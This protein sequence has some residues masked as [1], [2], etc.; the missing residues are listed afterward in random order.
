MPMSKRF[1]GAFLM[2]ALAGCGHA[3]AQPRYQLQMSMVEYAQLLKTPLFVQVT[4]ILKQANALRAENGLP[5]LKYD[6]SLGRAAAY[7]TQD[8][9][10]RNYSAHTTAEGETVED[11]FRKYNVT[12]SWS[13]EN[14]A[15]FQFPGDVAGTK[16]VE[17]AMNFWKNSPG[18]R[19]NI[20]GAHFRRTGIYAV[21]RASDGMWYYTQTFAD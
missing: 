3:P 1:L 9:A 12:F 16:S 2:A 21:R 4:Y 13:G 18:H 5:P 17:G 10:K 7:H 11:R 6:A 19:A 20:L 15:N 8:M 14:I